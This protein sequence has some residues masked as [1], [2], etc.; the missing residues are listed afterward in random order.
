MPEEV[1]LTEEDDDANEENDARQKALLKVK[2]EAETDRKDREQ[3]WKIINT[4]VEIE[5][6]LGVTKSDSFPRKPQPKI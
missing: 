5:V 2:H 6:Q 1:D 4:K 3:S